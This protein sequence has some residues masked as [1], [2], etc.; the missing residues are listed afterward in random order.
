MIRQA[1]PVERPEDHAFLDL[2][3]LWHEVARLAHKKWLARGCPPSG[4]LDDW[5][6]AEAELRQV[7]RSLH[8]PAGPAASDAGRAE[9]LQVE[10]LR[11]VEHSITRFLTESATL[12]EA[13]PRIL[14]V[15][16]EGLGWDV[17]LLWEVDRGAGRLRCRAVCT[18]PA[19]D[20]SE[21]GT[22]ARRQ[23][24]VRGEG[25]AGRVWAVE[26]PVWVGDIR[27]LTDW[28]VL[29]I[30]IR[31]GLHSATAFPIRNG[32]EFLGVMA[33]LGRDTRPPDD[34]LRQTMASI[35]GQIS[36]FIERRSAER[37]LR[38]V[39]G[40]GRV[41]RAIQ[42]GL[43]PR[44]VPVLP[45]FSL[46]GR[47]CPAQDVGGD[48]YDFVP[49]G[50]GGEEYVGVVVADASGHGVAAALLVAE[51]QAYLR[52]LAMTASDLGD[53]LR[54]TNARLCESGTDDHFVTLLV[55][56]LDPRRRSLV[57]AG[58]GH[59]PGYVLDPGGAVKA[60]LRSGNL[61]L[62]I[63]TGGETVVSAE[64]PLAAGDCVFLYT[65][66]ITEVTSPDGEFFGVERALAVFRDHAGRTA[67][68]S[69]EALY[70]T[71]Q[72]FSGQRPLVDDMTVVVVKVEPTPERAESC[73]P[74][75]A[76]DHPEAPTRVARSS[77]QTG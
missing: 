7:L 34:D 6:E 9:R 28:P 58:A 62:G 21:F 35:G 13:A 60:A 36:Q 64:V 46:C 68:E 40:E 4:E 59:C 53:I 42:K 2:S 45:P 63:R 31:S 17:G 50:V 75:S 37:R 66:G 10:R 25:L 22:V 69:I 20:L 15:I 14:S 26:T 3:A 74:Q 24:L 39:E 55:V 48:C 72:D 11:A 52:A 56:R 16:C 38:Q 65:D 51:T 33:F 41:A 54:L 29:E 5:L 76:G 27:A 43:L 30:A 49:L 12:E 67:E 73:Q 23:I 57:Y 44:S 61:P 71:V 77:K 19:A 47:C 32:V 8:R 18:P 70:R 1:D